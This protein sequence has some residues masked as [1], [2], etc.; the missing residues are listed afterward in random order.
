MSFSRRTCAA[1]TSGVLFAAAASAQ[2]KVYNDPEGDAVVRRTDSGNDG[3]L[4]PRTVLP[5]LVQVRLSGWLP[6][7]PVAD[8]Y[9]G[10]AIDSDDAH[11][12]RL[13]VVYRGLVNPPGPLGLGGAAYDPFRFGPSPVYGSIE[14]DVDRDRD[15]GGETRQVATN[16]YLANVARFGMLPD[17]SIAE[18]AAL[19]GVG[20]DYEGDCYDNPRFHHT[21][22]DFLLAFCGC[23]NVTIVSSTGDGDNT[24]EA[25][26]TWIV[27]GRFFQRSP[28]YQC[29]SAVFNGS[30]PGLYDPWVRLRF[31]HDIATDR[32]TV[33]LVYALDMQGAAALAGS[34]PQGID[35]NVANH[36]SIAEGVDDLVDGAEGRNVGQLTGCCRQLAIDWEGREP[37]DATDVS[38]WRV[39]ALAG[40]AYA[41]EQDTLFVWTDVGF[42]EVLGDFNNDGMV[43]DLDAAAFDAALSMLDG[44]PFDADGAIDG[45]VHIA[46]FGPNFSVYDLNGDGVMNSADRDII[47]L[48]ACRADWNGSGALDSQDFFD[49]LIDFFNTAADFNADGVTNSQDFFDFIGAFFAGC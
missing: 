9:T 2:V 39:Y 40:T 49:F 24:F 37:D 27:R 21:G 18:N 7:N 20:W 26:E 19:S 42:D 43:N 29:A 3:P 16:R 25:G 44:T 46:N 14:F 35:K 36:T 28:G 5:D 22:V 12:F 10:R 33:T 47:A 30:A 34:S 11:L 17:D 38:R 1:V 13:D 6:D 23:Y 4:D 32:T 41:Q 48:P 8:P 15:T 45:V 31:A